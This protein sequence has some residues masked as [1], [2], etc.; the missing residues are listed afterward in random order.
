[1]PGGS[2][3]GCVIAVAGVGVITVVVDRLLVIAV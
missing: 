2:G 1:L 3:L